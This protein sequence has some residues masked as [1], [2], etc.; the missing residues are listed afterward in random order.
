MNASDVIKERKRRT[1]EAFKLQLEQQ[2]IAQSTIMTGPITTPT[3]VVPPP[4]GLPT[5]VT[6]AAD[7][8]YN[9]PITAIGNITNIGNSPI[10]ERGF[11]WNMKG[12]PTIANNRVVSS[13]TD[14]GIF[15]GLVGLGQSIGFLYVR[16]YATNSTGTGYGEPIYTTQSLLGPTV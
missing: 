4:V 3:I 5:V 6:V 1:E 13:G 16:A 14:A 10:L 15:T 7:V 12:T 11:V 8:N 9:G 2:K